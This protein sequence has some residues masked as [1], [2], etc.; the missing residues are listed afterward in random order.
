MPDFGFL[1]M[2][3]SV[4]VLLDITVS[5]NLVL[6]DGTLDKLSVRV[7]LVLVNRDLLSFE[8]DRLLANYLGFLGSV[9]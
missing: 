4:S 1:D 9:A 8:D 6:V 3:R 5:S 7:H 2:G